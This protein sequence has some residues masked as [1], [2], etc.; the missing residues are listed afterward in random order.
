METIR[1]MKLKNIVRLIVVT[2][3]TVYLLYC[4]YYCLTVEQVPKYLDCG[5]VLSKSIE[6]VPAKYQLIEDLYLIVQFEKSG[7]RSV[8]CNRTTFY[9][10]EKGD[11][12]CF[13]LNKEVSK[14][15]LFN[16]GVGL[17]FNFL[18]VFSVLGIIIAVILPTKMTGLDL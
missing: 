7:I 12:V 16:W 5:K 6:Q 1:N 2:P 18:I 9:L 4:S 3:L 17:I 11:S 13:N 10:K 15:H 8:E 14:N